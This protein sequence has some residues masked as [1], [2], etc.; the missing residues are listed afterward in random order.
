MQEYVLQKH[1]SSVRH[2]NVSIIMNVELIIKYEQ[3]DPTK[4]HTPLVNIVL[5]DCF[6][7][8]NNKTS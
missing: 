4:K 1:F 3:T 7:L 5:I 2:V 6:N 8:M